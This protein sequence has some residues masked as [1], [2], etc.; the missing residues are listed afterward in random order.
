MTGPRAGAL[1]DLDDIRRF[2]STT[3]RKRYPYDN[4]Y[5]LLKQGCRRFGSDKALTFLPTGVVN[6]IAIDITFR[7]LSK[8]ITQTANMLTGLEVGVEDAVTI[9]L[10]MLPETH[11]A[12]WGASAAGIASP[13]NPFLEAEHIAEIINATGSKVLMTL[14]PGQDTRMWEKVT[15]VMMNAPALKAI[16]LVTSPG[17]AL[18]ELPEPPRGGLS[19]VDFNQHIATQ[20]NDQLTS[21]RTFSDTDIAMYLHTGGTTNRPKVARIS[22]GNLTFMAQLYIDMTRQEERFSCLSGLPL[23]HVFGII[24]TSLAAISAG[25]HLILM[26]PSGFRNPEVIKNFWHHV[27][28]SRCTAFATLRPAWR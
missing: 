4:T 1:A 5:D 9:L 17:F 27:A 3:H 22:H 26:T 23:F 13:I 12:L 10:P 14:A 24:A 25:R 28:R 8:R 16:V 20:T 18:S 19:M 2:E 11:Y 21:G 7:Q 15:A 6:D